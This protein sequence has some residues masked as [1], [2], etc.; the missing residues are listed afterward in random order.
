M[1]GHG[2]CKGGFSDWNDGSNLYVKGLPKT[3]DE[4]YLYKLFAPYGAIQSVKPVVQEW[5]AIGFVKYAHAEDAQA[6]IANVNGHTMSDGSVIQVSIKS[7][8]KGSGG[9]GG[10]GDALALA[11]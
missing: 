2:G 11:A 6:A 1:P 7:V 9:G 8:R 4:L 10:G 5:G 3:V